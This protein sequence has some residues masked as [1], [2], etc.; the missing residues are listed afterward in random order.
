MR[1]TIGSIQPHH[2]ITSFALIWPGV[3]Q[4]EQISQSSKKKRVEQSTR[5]FPHPPAPQGTPALGLGPLSPR[6]SR[7]WHRPIRGVRT[8]AEVR[9]LLFAWTLYRGR[10]LM[11]D[12]PHGHGWSSDTATTFLCAPL[13]ETFEKP[14]S[15]FSTLSRRSSL[16]F[17]QL[18]VNRK[19]PVPRPE[20]LVAPCAA[21][22]TP[23]L[24]SALLPHLLFFSLLSF[25][26]LNP[27]FALCFH[28]SF[29]LLFFF[30]SLSPAF[31][32]SNR[33]FRFTRFR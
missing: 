11:L 4:V 8:S 22:P 32:S 25:S 1:G 13:P 18:T 29:P 17:S 6:P 28:F 15:L 10:S 30:F 24:V 14:A 31:R 27:Y 7:G 26:S 20:A 19:T 16:C 3:Y 5:P 33:F 23:A 2:S 9:I 21:V 12:M